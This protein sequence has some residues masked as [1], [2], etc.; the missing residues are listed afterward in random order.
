MKAFPFLLALTCA[1]FAKDA[2]IAYGSKVTFL[3]TADGSPAPVFQWIKDGQ[4]IPGAT[5][6]TYVIQSFGPEHAG[7]YMVRASNVAGSAT[8]GTEGIFPPGYLAP[9]NPKIQATPKKS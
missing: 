6:S 5:G 7:R 9:M 1:A 3:A 2:P 8:S 4:D